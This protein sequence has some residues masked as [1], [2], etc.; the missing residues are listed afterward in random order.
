MNEILV[1]SFII[2]IVIFGLSSIVGTIFAAFGDDDLAGHCGIVAIVSLIV[3]FCIA[4]I[5][6]VLYG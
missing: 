3:L 6:A 1:F 5:G 2:A 4:G